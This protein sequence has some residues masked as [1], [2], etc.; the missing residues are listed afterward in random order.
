LY[1]RAIARLRSSAR[2]RTSLILWSAGGLL[3]TEA[4]ADSVAAV[5]SP[6]FVPIAAAAA[7]VWW[8]LI[9]AVFIGGAALLVT[10]DGADV[11][12]YGVPNGLT[13]MRA[14]ACLP[15]MLVAT[16]SLPGRIGLVLWGAVGG[17][18]GFLDAV[19]GFIARHGG[20]VTVLG[21]AMDPFMDSLFFITGAVGSAALGVVP[22]WLGALIAFRYGGPLLATPIVFVVRR[23]PELVHTVWG[24]RNTVLIGAVLTILY[25]VDVFGGPVSVVA[26]IV[27][28]PTL[29]PTMI[30]HFVALGQRVAD[31]PV[32]R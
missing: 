10:P 22:V 6:S 1:A 31:A 16:L 30:A 24:R 21:K 9:T 8:L 17:P 19:D 4:F 15:L 3:L 20:H 27:A 11:D 28:L 5:H 25:L 12:A 32:V 23:R 26:P 18:V 13:A 29:V 2:L 14:W 7:F